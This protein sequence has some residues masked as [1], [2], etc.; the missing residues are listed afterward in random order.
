MFGVSAAQV[1]AGSA[2]QVVLLGVASR[3]LSAADFGQFTAFATLAVWLTISDA[4]TNK[5]LLTL[6]PRGGDSGRLIATAF[7]VQLCIA[8]VLVATAVFF[9]PADL[10]LPFCLASATAPLS[11]AREVQAARQRGWVAGM[12]DLAGSATVVLLALTPAPRAGLGGMTLIA[13]SGLVVSRLLGGA[14][15]AVEALQA[16]LTWRPD[17]AV[18][19]RL[20]R[21]GRQFFLA[22]LA[23]L[24]G[25]HGLPWVAL[26]SLSSDEA[27]GLSG[28][29][30]MAALAPTLTG[31][32]SN[33][34]LPAYADAS[35]REDRV[36]I[37]GA[38]HRSLW[39]AIGAAGL[40]SAF[41]FFALP[42]LQRLWLGDAIP[43]PGRSTW[44]WIAVWTGAQVVILP[45]LSF[46]FGT[47][48][49]RRVASWSLAS[50]VAG[51]AAAYWAARNWG[52]AGFAAGV[53]WTY[54]GLLAAPVLFHAMTFLRGGNR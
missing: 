12:W 33:S 49:V 45:L 41:T 30:R 2:A 50:S 15:L 35:A 9:R 18:A 32:L 4:G 42:P 17:A 8:A 43:I 13:I 40:V 38:L 37:R 54:I 10:A 53:A 14:S 34:L 19:R 26:A 51:I 20:W 44:T 11:V 36:W 7:C 24:L 16:N 6:L 52:P 48:R 29:M 21:D 47:D 27:G 31:L 46:F 3:H 28:S 23:G 25:S 39:L 22:Q 1:V 5:A